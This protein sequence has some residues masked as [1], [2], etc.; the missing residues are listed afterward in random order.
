[1]DEKFRFIFCLSQFTSCSFFEATRIT[2]PRLQPQENGIFK[3]IFKRFLF[4][5][6]FCQLN[7]HPACRLLCKPSTFLLPSLPSFLT[8]QCPRLQCDAPSVRVLDELPEHVGLE[9]LD[10]QRLVVEV[11]RRLEREGGLC[12]RH[13]SDRGRGC[14]SRSGWKLGTHSV[15]FS[16]VLRV[17]GR[18][19]LLRIPSFLDYFFMESSEP[20]SGR[21]NVN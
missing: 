20:C 21:K 8:E 4:K 11:G 14:Q 7:R 5:L 2:L 13:L 16:L 12:V 1:M 15:R 3:R 9:L 19:V 10:D 6:K 18:V 17:H